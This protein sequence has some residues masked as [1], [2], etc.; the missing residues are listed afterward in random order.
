MRA[1]NGDETMHSFEH[2][3]TVNDRGQMPVEKLAEIV[4]G[5]LP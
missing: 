1:R 5:D 2:L 4:K 3:I